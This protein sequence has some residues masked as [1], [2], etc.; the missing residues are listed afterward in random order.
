MQ[1]RPARGYI[2]AYGALFGDTPV[3]EHTPNQKIVIRKPRGLK[4]RQPERAEQDRLA[5]W[6]DKTGV[7]FYAVPN[8]GRRSIGEAMNLRRSGLKAGVPDLCVPM[9]SAS[10]KYHALYIE[11]KAAKGRLSEAQ[12][13]WLRE[14]RV[15][16]NAAVVCYSW[17][18][19]QYVVINYLKN[20][21]YV[22]RET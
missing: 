19:A 6:L 18:E 8:G 16:G 1:R 9:A 15:R 22:L 13:W 2:N 5:A 20:P 4:R 11:M 3:G 10:G 14:L 7:L 17:S 12:S 21:S